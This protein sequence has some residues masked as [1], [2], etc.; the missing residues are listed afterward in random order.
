MKDFSGQ[1]L[2]YK[3]QEYLVVLT[4][5]IAF[6]IGFYYQEFS[7]TVMIIFIGLIVTLIVSLTHNR[8]F[9]FF[10]SFYISFLPK[11]TRTKLSPQSQNL[12]AN[13][14]LKSP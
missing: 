4:G 5:I 6:I 7:Y 11:L 12:A 9:S 3:I 8:L 13:F 10:S 1:D 2:A 14:Q